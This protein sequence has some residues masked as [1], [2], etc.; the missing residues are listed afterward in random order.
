MKRTRIALSAYPWPKARHPSPYEIFHLDENAP[1]SVIKARYYE[2]VKLYHP[3][4]ERHA[5]SDITNARFHEILKA[6]AI[7]TDPRARS[8]YDRFG[9]G[10]SGPLKE[11]R[12]DG[13]RFDRFSARQSHSTTWD[14]FYTGNKRDEVL[15]TSNANFIGFIVFLSAVGAIVQAMRLSRA[16]SEINERA[17]KA[18]FNT[19]RDLAES[20]RLARDLNRDERR[21]LF[22]A[23]RHGDAHGYGND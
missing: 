2:L 10:W 21:Q 19:A 14:G 22:L 23:Q 8:A 17:D 13:S 9:V 18:H 12:R 7:L 5:P 20:R 11:A 3:D 4:K 6:H 16:S 15:Y 1:Q